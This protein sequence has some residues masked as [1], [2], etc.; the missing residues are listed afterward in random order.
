MRSLPTFPSQLNLGVGYEMTLQNERALELYN[1][2]QTDLE[3]ALSTFVDHQKPPSWLGSMRTASCTTWDYPKLV[4]SQV[5]WQYLR[6]VQTLNSPLLHIRT[7]LLARISH[8]LF[9][10]GRAWTVSE[11]CISTLH[12]KAREMNMLKVRWRRYIF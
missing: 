6:E 5:S 8:L 2:A 1:E 12:T 3:S 10:Q 4:W 7:F 11:L 9:L